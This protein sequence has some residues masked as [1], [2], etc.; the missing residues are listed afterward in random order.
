MLVI[1]TTPCVTFPKKNTEV[2]KQTRKIHHETHA[3]VQVV[4]C[5]NAH[6]TPLRFGENLL[7]DG[8]G[9]HTILHK[10]PVYE[11]TFEKPVM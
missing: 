4:I 10:L 11:T 6:Y 5:Q 1:R 7:A 9:L 3:R 8:M 2:Q